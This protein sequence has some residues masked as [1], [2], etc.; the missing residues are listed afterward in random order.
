V[1][2]GKVKKDL[3]VSVSDN[4]IGITAEEQKRI[5]EVFY[6][7]SSGLKDKTPGTG[8]GLSITRGIVE[9]HGGR[10]WFESEGRNKGSRFTFA[11]PIVVK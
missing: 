7:A 4:G 5:F 10:I 3:V 2:A 6:Q 9:K 11:I 1:E 8:L